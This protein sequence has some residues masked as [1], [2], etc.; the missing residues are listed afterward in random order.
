[1]R[2]DPAEVARAALCEL[3]D[4]TR[5][6]LRAVLSEYGKAGIQTAVLG[7]TTY[8]PLLVHAADAPLLLF[9]RGNAAVLGRETMIAVVGARKS[10]RSA[11]LAAFELAQYLAHCG[12]TIVS[13]LAYGIDAAAH[14]G[15]IASGR[16]GSTIAV[17][18]HGLDRVYPAAHRELA[19]Q[20]VESGGAIVSQFKLGINALPHHFLIRNQVIAGI[21]VGT[22]VIQAAERS[23]SLAT[24]RAALEAGR[25]VLTLPGDYNDQRFRGSNRLLRDGAH[26]ITELEDLHSIFPW[27]QSKP[28]TEKDG[29]SQKTLELDPLL[30]FLRHNGETALCDIPPKFGDLAQLSA[31][32]VE[33]ELDGLVLR[34]AA[35]CFC[36]APY[37]F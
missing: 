1:M 37:K 10:T 20:I 36:A 31:R 12:A 32:L 2:S 17:V 6:E 13:G 7:G 4:L 11:E 23:G 8:P 28:H 34:Q 9:A 16:E 5:C 21:S 27:L 29:A 26:L 14:R 15:A 24:A 3:S 22:F 25:E 33:L 18:A 35:N 19:H 30:E